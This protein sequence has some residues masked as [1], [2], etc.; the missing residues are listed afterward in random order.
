MDETTKI[1]LASVAQTLSAKGANNPA[2]LQAMQQ[3]GISGKE[4]QEALEA[5]N[6]FYRKE[7]S[8]RQVFQTG[9]PGH[10]A[11]RLLC[12]DN[13]CPCPG[14][15]ALTVGKNAYLFIPKTV[16]DTRRNALTARDLEKK[17]IPLAAGSTA[18]ILLCRM[19]AERRNLDLQTAAADAEMWYREGLAPLRPT[20]LK[21]QAPPPVSAPVLPVLPQ[22]SA[23]P[24]S[25][26][27]SVQAPASAENLSA[28]VPTGFSPPSVSAQA[29]ASEE[30][31]DE[32]VDA[33]YTELKGDVQKSLSIFKVVKVFIAAG[34]MV[35]AFTWHGGNGMTPLLAIGLG[36]YLLYSIYDLIRG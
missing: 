27:V 4:A 33:A 1:L 11:S 10:S 30:N 17:S 32:I 36:A 19:G 26:A 16:V 3:Q 5:G 25:P 23:K 28:Q 12:S 20:P 13:S 31:L 34:L 2:I 35:W 22:T 9:A 18:P 24:V 15:E 21:T 6:D 14:N 8:K 29:P 7:L